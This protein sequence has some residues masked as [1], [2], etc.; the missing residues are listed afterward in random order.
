[1]HPKEAGAEDYSVLN[2]QRKVLPVP[3]SGRVLG[4]DMSFTVPTYS[5]GAVIIAQFGNDEFLETQARFERTSND[6]QLSFQ[7]KNAPTSRTPPRTINPSETQ[8]IRMILR[9]TEATEVFLNGKLEGIVKPVPLKAWSGAIQIG[10]YN[11]DSPLKLA[12]FEIVF[13][14][15][16]FLSCPP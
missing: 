8:T 11:Q 14:Q 1:L 4:M 2:G 13:S 9:S 10:A 3:K 5:P 15:I 6:S 7:A 16:R 12:E